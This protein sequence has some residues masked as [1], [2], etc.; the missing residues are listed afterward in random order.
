MLKRRGRAEQTHTG[1]IFSQSRAGS[2]YC[3][4]GRIYLLYTLVSVSASLGREDS[5]NEKC[6]KTT[7]SGSENF[8]I[9]LLMGRHTHTQTHKHMLLAQL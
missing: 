7:M 5:E 6:L 1:W 4:Q 2:I 8:E 9:L 3:E